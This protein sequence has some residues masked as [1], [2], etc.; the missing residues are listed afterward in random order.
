MSDEVL[1]TPAELVIAE[2]L[3]GAFAAVGAEVL[4]VTIDPR[5]LGRDPI[6]RRVA[7]VLDFP[8]RVLVEGIAGAD[9]RVRPLPRRHRYQS[10]R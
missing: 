7:V 9:E 8:L 10:R 5:E 2:A 1:M 4:V 3:N 6:D